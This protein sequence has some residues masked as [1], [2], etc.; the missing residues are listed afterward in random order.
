MLDFGSDLFV[1]VVSS[2]GHAHLLGEGDMRLPACRCT[3]SRLGEHLVDLLEGQSLGLWDKEVRVDE[4]ACAQATPDPEDVRAEIA[5]IRGGHVWG[6][7]GD[8]GVPEPVGGGGE[9]DTTGAD[10]EREDFT[11][12]HPSTRTPC[13]GEEEDKDGNEGDLGVDGWDTVSDRGT[14]GV[15]VGVVETLGNT[16]DGDKVL[17]DKHAESTPDEKWPS[18]KPFN[19]PE[20][21]GSRADVDES[22]DERDQEGVLDGMGRLE[23]RRRVVED[24]VDTGPLLHHLERSTQDCAADVG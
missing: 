2:L 11:N 3:R 15:E 10:G 21:D 9:S 14:V 1:G 20:R 8:D 7:D 24:E 19:G 5:L 17:A 6:D 23:E 13:R 22:E 4:C 18:S 12:E 16:D